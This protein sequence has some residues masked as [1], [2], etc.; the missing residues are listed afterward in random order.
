M[1]VV[2]RQAHNFCVDPIIGQEIVVVNLQATEQIPRLIVTIQMKKQ[3]VTE[4]P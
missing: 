2:Q 1:L 3:L 4:M